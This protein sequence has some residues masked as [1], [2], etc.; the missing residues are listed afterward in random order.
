MVQEQQQPG[1]ITITSE[2]TS[3]LVTSDLVTSQMM[4]TDQ[5][6]LPSTD[7][8]SGSEAGSNTLTYGV[9]TPPVNYDTTTSESVSRNRKLYR[10]SVSFP[11]VRQVKHGL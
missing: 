7:I 11:L 3:D 9:L 4:E 2:T 1:E 10:C 6:T 5:S 8:S